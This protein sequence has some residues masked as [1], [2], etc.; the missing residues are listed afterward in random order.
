LKAKSVAVGAT[1]FLLVTAQPFK[2]DEWD[3]SGE[4]PYET[5]KSAEFNNV[6]SRRQ[7]HCP[8]NRKRE[9]DE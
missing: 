5:G 7:H 6:S 8:D 4:L 1:L 2:T 3:Q 9:Q